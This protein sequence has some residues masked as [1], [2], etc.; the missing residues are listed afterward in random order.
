MVVAIADELRS[1]AEVEALTDFVRKMLIQLKSS[2]PHLFQTV[3]GEMVD[4]TSDRLTGRQVRERF[5]FESLDEEDE[6]A[7]E[8]RRLRHLLEARLVQFLLTD[9]GQHFLKMLLRQQLEEAEL[10][11]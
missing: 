1:C 3:D 6:E 11:I 4:V 5:G 8:E 2:Y 10:G 9:E 7:W